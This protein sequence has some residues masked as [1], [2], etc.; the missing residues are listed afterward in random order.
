MAIRRIRV[1]RDLRCGL[2]HARAV[3]D[4]SVGH[5]IRLLGK[6]AMLCSLTGRMA[7]NRQHLTVSDKKVISAFRG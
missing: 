3:S 2:G 7:N 1:I 5:F 4:L 6:P